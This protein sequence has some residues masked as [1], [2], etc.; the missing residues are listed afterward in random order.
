LTIFVRAPLR[1]ANFSINFGLN[2]AA[3]SYGR[4]EIF[5]R[6]K[7]I[8]AKART[9]RWFNNRSGQAFGQVFGKQSVRG[10]IGFGYPPRLYRSS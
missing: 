4:S 10:V 3:I 8:A 2:A 6:Q 1:L 9:V 5:S 7:K